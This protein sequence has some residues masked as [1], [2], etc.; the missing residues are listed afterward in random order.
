VSG[1]G[2]P[3]SALK[4]GGVMKRW[5]KVAL[6]LLLLAA[7]LSQTPFLYRRYTL[8]RLQASIN[9]L[10]AQHA[11]ANIDDPYIDY[12]GVMHVHSHL[13]GHSTGTF[14]ELIA[15]AKSNQLSFVVMTEHPARHVDTMEATLRGTHDGVLFINGSELNPVADDRLLIVPG[16]RPVE[17]TDASATQQTIDRAKRDGKL[18]FV[19]YPEQRR[20]WDVSG[21]D[22]IEVYNLYTNTKQISYARLLFDGL[23]SYSSYPELLFATFYQRP[24]GNLKRWDE[25][26][27]AGNRPL[28]AIAGNDAHSN[29]GLS[30][31]HLTGEKILQLKLDPYERSF[32]IVRMHV[33]VERGRQALSTGVNTGVSTEVILAALARGHCFIGFDLFG[34]TSGFR[35]TADNGAGRSVILGDQIEMTQGAAVRLSVTTPVPARMVF[36]RNGGVIYEEREATRK[37]LIVTERG[38]YR[39]EIYLDQ[40][41]ELLRDRPWIISNPIF[42]K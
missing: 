17:S 14:D 12:K 32:R 6:V 5:K 3:N 19:A 25:L 16:M 22:G 37:E 30:L 1:E 10:N 31:Q 20:N 38:A 36:F 35:F 23:W 24:H 40:L 8:G 2:F 11:P 21:Y 28:I 34:D 9:S 13:G 4:D 15:A 42:V 39:V 7:P 41:G 26:M 27:V 18:A 29:V 33:L